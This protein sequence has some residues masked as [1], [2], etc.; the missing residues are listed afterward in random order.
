[1]SRDPERIDEVL[2]VVEK[3]WREY[4]DLR[5]GQL[6]CIAANEANY[7][8]DPFYMEDYE[9]QS[10]LERRLRDEN[11]DVSP[12]RSNGYTPRYTGI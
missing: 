9:L 12:S 10:V 7:D 8:D 4:P 3:Y 5:L 11:D 2:D 1:M 6:I